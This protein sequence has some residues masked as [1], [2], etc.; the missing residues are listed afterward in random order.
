MV[1][2]SSSIF[3]LY[4]LMFYFVLTLTIPQLFL[5]PPN[6]MPIVTEQFKCIPQNFT[7]THPL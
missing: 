2:C 5:I 3:P 6:F 7:V 4:V 1:H